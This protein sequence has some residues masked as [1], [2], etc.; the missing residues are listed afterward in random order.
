MW[1]Q[2][3][4][5]GWL[6]LRNNRVIVQAED[7]I[8]AVDTTVRSLA[9]FLRTRCDATARRVVWPTAAVHL[10]PAEVAEIAKEDAVRVVSIGRPPVVAVPGYWFDDT[11]LITV[12]GLACDA[13]R[14]FRGALDVQAQALRWL[15]NPHPR[16][17]L[18]SE[19]HRLA[20][21]DLAIV[22]AYDG[23][24]HRPLW[25]AASP[26]GAS[27][28]MFVTRVAGRMPFDLPTLRELARHQILP[29]EAAVIGEIPPRCPAAR[30]RPNPLVEGF[31]RIRAELR[32]AVN[33]W[34]I[35]RG[36][37]HRISHAVRRRLA[38]SRQS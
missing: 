22:C 14:P 10:D 33:E 27:L 5:Q 4:Q 18:A 23:Q 28:D 25:W 31:A 36:N 2:I 30:I 16:P 6:R 35:I 19:A 1:E 9:G 20:P 7:Q 12:T 15:G 26:N 34:R 32:V 21:S 29:A 37:L 8:E 3:V 11:F 13:A 24:D 17:V 38:V